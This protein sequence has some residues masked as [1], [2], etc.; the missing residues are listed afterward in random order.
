MMPTEQT[1]IYLLLVA[2]ILAALFFINAGC[3]VEIQ[4][5]PCDNALCTS[6]SVG[7]ATTKRC[8]CIED[9]GASE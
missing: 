5:K 8:T 1:R 9:E 4:K 6:I 2:M 3:H 7:L